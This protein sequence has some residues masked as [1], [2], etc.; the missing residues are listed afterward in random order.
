VDTRQLT[1]PAF[2]AVKDRVEQIVLGEKF[3]AYVDGL[4]AKAQIDKKM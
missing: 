4:R 3:K 1:P 2:D